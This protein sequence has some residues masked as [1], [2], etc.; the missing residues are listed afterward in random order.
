MHYATFLESAL[1]LAGGVLDDTDYDAFNLYLVLENDIQ[2]YI[3]KVSDETKISINEADVDALQDIPNIG[4]TLA[5]RIVQYRNEI[6]IFSYL[7]Q[8]LDVQ[9]IGTKIFNKIRDFII[10]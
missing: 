1:E 9:G 6:G 8:L 10:L 7:E 2:I 4:L 3:P 5:N